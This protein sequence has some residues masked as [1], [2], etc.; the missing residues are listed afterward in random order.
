MS[1]I[2][3]RLLIRGVLLD[4]VC[5]AWKV[6]EGDEVD[7]HGF[8]PQLSYLCSESQIASRRNLHEEDPAYPD[9]HLRAK[10]HFFDVVTGNKYNQV[11]FERM[12]EKRN[13][14]TDGEPSIASSIPSYSKGQTDVDHQTEASRSSSNKR[15]DDGENCSSSSHIGEVEDLDKVRFDSV[16]HSIMGRTIFTTE[17]GFFG[18]GVKGIEKGD[19][20]TV[21]F[22]INFPFVLR[23]CG[24]H[25][26]FVG[27]S[28]IGGIM[29]GELMEFV[30]NDT[31]QARSFCI[32]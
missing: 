32:R 16:I 26:K 15:D 5:T 23:D 9:Q 8:Y 24:N 29:N 25:Y 30:D 3:P 6:Q 1:S 31:L 7:I 13:R 14:S 12:F 17:S 10:D 20:V 28:R 2:G 11:Q 21:F 18:M 19:L 4:T 22:G 27:A